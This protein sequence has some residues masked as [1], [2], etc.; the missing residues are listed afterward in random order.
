MQYLLRLSL[1]LLAGHT[2]LADLI[3]MSPRSPVPVP[4]AGNENPLE[5][6]QF[7]PYTFDVCYSFNGQF[8]CQDIT[9]VCCQLDD[10][11]NPYTCTSPSPLPFS[12]KLQKL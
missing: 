12:L 11:T 6:R 1:L 7:C 2:T 5:R 8:V 4:E 3:L 10:G 9:E